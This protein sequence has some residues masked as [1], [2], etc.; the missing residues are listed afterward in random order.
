MLPTLNE[1]ERA[2]LFVFL[3]LIRRAKLVVI[4]MLATTV[5]AA[6]FEGSTIGLLAMA[7]KALAEGEAFSFSLI[8]G[9]IGLF[10]DKLVEGR[11]AVTIFLLLTLIA[12]IAQLLKSGIQFLSKY[13]SITLK[14]SIAKKIQETIT[15]TVIELPYIEVTKYPVG[16]L[17][18]VVMLGDNVSNRLMISVLNTGFLALVHVVVYVC[19]L[20]F[21]SVPFTLVCLLLLIVLYG[22]LEWLVRWLKAL[23]ERLAD[24]F[25]ETGRISVELLGAPRLV[26][27]FNAG[28]FVSSRINRERGRYLE[29]RKRSEIIANGLNPLI[30]V[31]TIFGASV[32]LVIIIA[33]GG[34][35]TLNE[36]L[37]AGIYGFVLLRT[38]PQIRTLNHTRVVFIETLPM[39][40]KLD[41]F[42]Q[43]S[44]SHDQRGSRHI[45]GPLTSGVKFENVRFRYPGANQNTLSDLS[46][47]FPKMKTI[48]ITGPSGSGKSTL[49]DIFLGL[50]KPDSGRVLIDGTDLH[51][52]D[53][54]SWF[55][56]L[57]VVDQHTLLLHGS[58]RDN[59]AFARPEYSMSE[60]ES[61][62]RA[63]HAHDFIMRLERGYDTN[64]GERGYKLSGGELQRLAL[65]R[66]L[67]LRPEILVLDEATSALDPDTEQ[68]IQSTLIEFQHTA[69]IL[70]I[71]H[72]FSSIRFADTVIF[73][74]N[75]KIVKSGPPRDFMRES[76]FLE[77]DPD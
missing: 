7:L 15:K 64:I 59:I 23:S 60:I 6:I 62:A 53:K 2:S 58:V 76:A 77:N 41:E 73:M 18:T 5:V 13:I 61:A 34:V 19:I 28:H 8:L 69:T 74:E 16:V 72:R 1:K 33:V 40:A 36:L 22:S 31:I 71:A 48:A 68:L 39:L 26:R 50:L 29:T 63:A 9:S 32:G 70:V 35:Q 57:G 45:L 51:S 55:Q 3:G 47:E 42:L 56:K 12:A 21:I 67:I 49:A 30:N 44:H 14:T 24:Q 10:F 37:G 66:A 38:I 46:F 17:T 75:G 25:I 27:L 52:V 65:A 4:A 54:A 43:R 20:F 11:S